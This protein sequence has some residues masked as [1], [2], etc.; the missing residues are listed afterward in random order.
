AFE[1]EAVELAAV[2]GAVVVNPAAAAIQGGAR[3]GEMRSAEWGMRSRK[4]ESEG[5]EFA[6]VVAWLELYVGKDY[7]VAA[8]SAF[9]A[10]GLGE[11]G[12]GAI[13]NVQGKEDKQ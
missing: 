9:Q 1:Q 2:F 12:V 10:K 4:W 7:A 13:C 5:S 11:R 3:L 6:G 8:H